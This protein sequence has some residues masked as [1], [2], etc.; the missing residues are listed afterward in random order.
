MP[1]LTKTD[2]MLYLQCHKSLWLKKH[3]PERYDKKLG[4][5]FGDDGDEVKRYTQQLFL[6]DTSPSLFS[7]PV[8]FQYPLLTDDG[9]YICVDVLESNPD[10][11]YNLYEVKS[12][13]KKKN[14]HIKD[15]CF[16][17]IAL[18]KYGLS[19]RDVFIIH[20]NAN[21]VLVKTV[22]PHQLLQKVCVTQDVRNCEAEI[23]AEIDNAL[24]LLSENAI[25]E[26]GCECYWKTRPNHCDAFTYFNRIPKENSVWELRRI[27]ESKLQTLLRQRVER[28][29]DI[30]HDIELS[31]KQ[32][33]QVHSAKT[34]KPIVQRKR[35]AEM[36]NTL[37]FPLYFFDYETASRAVPRIPG[38]KPWQHIPF[39]FSLH[40]LHKNGSLDHKKYLSE[41][42][43]LH[44]I[45]SLL[46]AL[47]DGI[48]PCG[49]VIVWHAQFERKRNHEMGSLFPQ[50][51][52]YLENVNRR[53]FDLEDIFKEA[54]IDT[55]FCGSTSIKNVLPVMCPHLSYESLEVQDG[56][57]AMEQWF[58]MLN[59]TGRKRLEI[60]NALLK[61][62]ELDTYAMVELY[63]ALL[64]II[65]P[66]H[67][68]SSRLI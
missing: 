25:D 16:Q 23:R 41:A 6:G 5:S 18:E 42:L 34:R 55:R 12:S 38:T 59:A 17:M 15:A 37:V 11:T 26:R 43:N 13:T 53:L 66:T 21:Y 7:K 61:Y 54:Y 65:S 58:V 33:A 27:R 44:H 50:H 64:N 47:R 29:E 52:A 8:R 68:Q 36:L 56:M 14:N 10:G 31:V 51:R 35:I 67:K 4:H 40:I 39:Q 48:D 30:P 24:A 60:R 22:D 20:F 19:V 3:K 1:N 63:R 9:M 32:S 62:C 46:Q 28:L 49:S 57:Q 2:F 45:E